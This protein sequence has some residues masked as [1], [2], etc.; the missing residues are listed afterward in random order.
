[1]D[2]GAYGM[3]RSG[4]FP[5]TETDAARGPAC[6]V[7]LVDRRTGATHRING[8]PLTLLTRNPRDAVEELLAGRDTRVWE[9]R[10]EVLGP[11]RARA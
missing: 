10:V 2:A 9:A 4:W 11:G 7:S 3:P 1:M 6:A 5:P 8:R